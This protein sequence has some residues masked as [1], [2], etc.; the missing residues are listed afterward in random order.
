MPASNVNDTA[1][2]TAN[3][4][5]VSYDANGG[6]GAPSATTYTYNPDKYTTL[7]SMFFEA[8]AEVIADK[9]SGGTRY[10][11][12]L[13][14]DKIHYKVPFNKNTYK[15]VIELRYVTGNTFAAELGIGDGNDNFEIIY[16]TNRED[17]P[18]TLNSGKDLSRYLSFSAKLDCNTLES[19]PE[20]LALLIMLG[21]EP[22]PTFECERCGDTCYVSDCEVLWRCEDCKDKIC[23]HTTGAG[24]SLAYTYKRLNNNLHLV[25]TSCYYC[26]YEIVN[27]VSHS[28]SESGVCTGCGMPNNTNNCTSYHDSYCGTC[29]WNYSTCSKCGYQWYY[30]SYCSHCG[31]DGNG[32]VCPHNNV[33]DNGY[34]FDCNEFINSGGG[35]D[36]N[37]YYWYCGDDHGIG[38]KYSWSG[39]AGEQPDSCPYCSGNMYCDE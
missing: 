22:D 2:A 35:G 15:N 25:T 38:C 11:Y 34:C 30:D 19:Y 32:E 17:N 13:E 28:F 37:Y 18:L 16:S 1:N 6:T 10:R 23:K 24:S 27:T 9:T 21:A 20:T 12:I 39:P 31:Y 4:Y 26:N 3:T 8:G 29:G 33:G 7:S 36:E 14:C 5:S